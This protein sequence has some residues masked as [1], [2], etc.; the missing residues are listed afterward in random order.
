MCGWCLQLS[1]YVRWMVVNLLFCVQILDIAQ[2]RKWVHGLQ[3]QYQVLWS[4]PCGNIPSFSYLLWT[5]KPSGFLPLMVC[6]EKNAAPAPAWLCFNHLA[7][8]HMTLYTGVA[9]W[10]AFSQLWEMW[11]L[12]TDDFCMKN[13]RNYL[14]VVVCWQGRV[15]WTLSSTKISNVNK[16][17]AEGL[18][19]KCRSR[20]GGFCNTHSRTSR[21]NKFRRNN[22]AAAGILKSNVE[23]EHPQP[24][25]QPI[26]VNP[27]Y[28]P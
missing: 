24:M 27:Q 3:S 10:I 19:E 11:T 12:R 28:S 16:Q 14:L 2:I 18:L 9:S 17:H 21:L 1:L 22:R 25:W 6:T 23:S 8:Q 7:Y 20:L 15:W 5:C 26:S 13:T 4:R